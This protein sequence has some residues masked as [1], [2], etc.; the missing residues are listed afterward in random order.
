MENILISCAGGPAAVGA[1]KSLKKINFKGRIVT[2]DCDPLAVGRY[3]GDKNYIV[4][5]S[6][7]K[8]Y[9]SE[10]LNIIKKEKTT[11]IIPTGDSDIKHFSKHKEELNTL[12]AVVFMSD[13]DTI[14]KCQDKRLFFDY[15]SQKFPLPFTSSNYKDLKFPMFAKPEYGS[16]SRGAKVCYK[17]FDIKTLDKEESVHRSSNYLF[18]E[19]LPGK[20]YTVDVL[21]DLESNPVVVVPRERL[22]IKAGISSKGRVVKHPVI[23]KLCIDLCEHLSIKG[24][25]CI[26]L[27]EDSKGNPKFIEV[28][29]RLGGGT[30][31]STLAGVNF[32][33]LILKIKNNIKY[34]IPKMYEITVLRYYNEIVI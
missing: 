21:C 14:I 28:N 6:T 26:Q 30:Y 4:P 12:G 25:V 31:F 10:V 11:I 19:F 15:C 7:S 27:K 23:E 29:P 1:I 17:S 18:Q 13:Y 34:N 5:L 3:L 32:L 24:P 2:I 22:Q 16:G 9:W 20:E 33:D 8:D